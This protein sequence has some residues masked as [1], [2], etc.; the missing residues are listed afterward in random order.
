MGTH[1]SVSTHYF[2][3]IFSA[4]GK[5][6]SLFGDSKLMERKRKMMKVFQVAD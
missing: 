6:F 2:A 5:V 1:Y 3:L 4:H